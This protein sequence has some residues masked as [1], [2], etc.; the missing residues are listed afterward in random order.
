MRKQN[1]GGRQ[2]WVLLVEESTK[3]KKSFFL[4]QKNEH[5]EIII[6]WIKA[7]KG[8]HKIHVKIIMCNNAGEN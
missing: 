8:S 2:P 4:K 3:Y 1:M 7:L 6:V 5:L